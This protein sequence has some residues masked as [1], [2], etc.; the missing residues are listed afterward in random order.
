MSSLETSGA[1]PRS[2]R[3]VMPAN[4]AIRGLN[5]SFIRKSTNLPNVTIY[6]TP[7]IVQE[8][9]SAHLLMLNKKPWAWKVR[10]PLPYR[11]IKMG[12]ITSVKSY[13]NPPKIHLKGFL[14]SVIMDQMEAKFKLMETME[15][16]PLTL[17]W[18]MDL[19]LLHL[20]KMAWLVPL[21]VA[22]RWTNLAI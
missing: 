16:Y 9:H 17:K 7:V 3:P 12:I 5:N 8:V 6:K 10:L 1:I 11:P 13:Q 14:L 19:W 4:I 18:G 20:K 21:R 2:V 22:M 15:V